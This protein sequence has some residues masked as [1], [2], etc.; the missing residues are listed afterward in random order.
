MT[1]SDTRT[2]DGVATKTTSASTAPDAIDSVDRERS[3][4]RREAVL[5]TALVG[6]IAAVVLFGFAFPELLAPAVAI[7]VLAAIVALDLLLP[8]GELR[9]MARNHWTF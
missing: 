8:S 6:L 7:A 5:A 4:S 2:P 9:Q 3:S 1:T